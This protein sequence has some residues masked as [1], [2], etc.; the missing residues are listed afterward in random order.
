[1]KLECEKILEDTGATCL[2]LSNIYGKG[3]SRGSVISDIIKQISLRGPILLKNLNAIRDF[4][5]IDDVADSILCSC[6]NRAD[7]ILNIG[8]GE[9]ISIR[10]LAK[11]AVQISKR[12]NQSVTSKNTVEVKSCLKLCLKKQN[13][14]LIG[15]L[16]PI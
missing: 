3:M 13:P 16:K 12:A 15:L 2:R 1:M 9:A 8:S 5:W 11:L 6:I 10:E 4:V 7:A 14:L